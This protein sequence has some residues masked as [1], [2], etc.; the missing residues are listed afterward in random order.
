MLFK[1]FTIIFLRVQDNI[2]VTS[3]WDEQIMTLDIFF[4]RRVHTTDPSFAL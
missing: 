1:R 3:N 4:W 2:E